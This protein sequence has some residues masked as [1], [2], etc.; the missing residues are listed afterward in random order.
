MKKWEFAEV[1]QFLNSEIGSMDPSN[2]ES[3]HPRDRMKEYL[4]FVS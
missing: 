2:D 1:L 4:F 3:A